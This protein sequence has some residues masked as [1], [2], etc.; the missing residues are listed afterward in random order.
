MYRIKTLPLCALL[1]VSLIGCSS[2]SHF[3]TRSYTL[4][5][6][7]AEQILINRIIEDEMVRLG[8]DVFPLMEQRGGKLQPVEIS[9]DVAIVTIT[10]RGHAAIKKALDELQE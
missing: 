1:L 7:D 6:S 2:T 10:P 4:Q 8:D 3:E 5:N 9:D